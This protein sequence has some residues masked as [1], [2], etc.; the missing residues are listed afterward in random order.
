M[1]G[2]ADNLYHPYLLWQ[3]PPG[4]DRALDV[5]C[6]TGLFA[7]R[8]A[9]RA[10]SVEA[11]DRSP[12]MIA[13]A[14]AASGDT[15]NVRYVEADVAG[16]DLARYDFIACVASLHHLPF[17]ETI[18]RLREALTPGGVLAVIGCYRA[19]TPADYLRDLIAIP[20]N[21]AANTAARARAR[22]GD[23]R[24][25]Q[26]GTAPVMAPRMTFPEIRREA[27]RLLPGATLRRRLFWRYSLTYRRPPTS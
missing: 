7:R 21:L 1:P 14:R 11:V 26:V 8:L 19:S 10:R 23:R 12:E 24:V 22:H 4:C 18:T 17:A 2:R 25:G 27:A 3:V 20:A 5:G 16:Y 9:P 6:G 15:P 13:Q